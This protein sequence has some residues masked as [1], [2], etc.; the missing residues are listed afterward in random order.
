MAH[1]NLWCCCC[2]RRREGW[3]GSRTKDSPSDGLS[4]RAVGNCLTRWNLYST[5]LVQ[6]H[7]KPS[8]RQGAR[9]L[10]AVTKTQRLRPHSGQQPIYCCTGSSATTGGVRSRARTETKARGGTSEHREGSAWWKGEGKGETAQQIHHIASRPYPF[11]TR[12]YWFTACISNADYFRVRLRAW[13]NNCRHDP[14][15]YTSTSMPFSTKTPS[16]LRTSQMPKS[17][18]MPSTRPP[19][20]SISSERVIT[21]A[22]VKHMRYVKRRISYQKWCFCWV[23]WETTRRRW[24]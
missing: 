11:Y 1:H 6:V 17:D 15:T 16:L 23:E 22:Q 10:F 8:T 20:W 2:Y 4:S 19:G 13:F 9:V 7:S 3:V 18:S 12:E 24:I 21:I 14:I 5:N